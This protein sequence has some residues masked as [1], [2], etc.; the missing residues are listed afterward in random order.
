MTKNNILLFSLCL[1]LFACKK[2]Q[3][4]N[5]TEESRVFFEN[6]ASLYTAY[7]GSYATR[8]VKDFAPLNSA[9]KTDTVKLNIQTTGVA[10]SNDRNVD[11]E[12][13]SENGQ[14]GTDYIIPEK[15]PKIAA[16][17]YT[18]VFRV[19]LLRSK[20]MSKAPVT[21]NL[22]I[23]ANDNFNLGPVADTSAQVSSVNFNQKL[24][25]IAIQAKDIL[26]KP[27]NWESFIKTYFGEYSE[28][29]LRFINDIL[30]RTVFA[31]N[32]TARTMTNYKT[33]LTNALKTY[34]AAHPDAPLTD[35][36][37]VLITF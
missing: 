9:I 30:K 18:T 25:K 35:E 31:S 10:S 32:T 19:V 4:L 26:L 17:E 3:L 36:N 1:T 7:P 20:P 27:D 28:A 8:L 13:S 14:E 21:V 29:K 15:S 34:N 12:V 33:Q 23:K 37:G 24:L 5:Y 16:G 2:E 6:G 11:I 22:E